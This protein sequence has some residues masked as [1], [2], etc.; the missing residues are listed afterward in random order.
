M[1]NEEHHVSSIISC[2]VLVPDVDVPNLFSLDYM[3]LVCLGVM[4]KLID[5]W[6]SNGSANVRLSSLKIKQ[7]SSSL[8]KLRN[9]ITNDFF[10]IPRSIEEYPRFKATELRQLLLYTGPIALKNVLSTEC[11][12]HFMALNIAM[13]ILLSTD[14]YLYLDY[15]ATLLDYFVK[16]FEQM[17]GS[18]FIS[19]NVHSLLHLV[20]D[21]MKYGSLDN[22]SCFPFENYMKILK[23]MIRKHDNPL[24]QIIKRFDEIYNNDEVKFKIH[25]NIKFT[26]KNPDCFILTYE[27]EVV[28][29]IEI[30][31]DSTTIVGQ[32]Y[33]SKMD[34][35]EK[36][37]RSSKLNIFTVSNLS[38]NTK[39]W[40]VSKI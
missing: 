1:N 35:F 7:L 38:E 22:C 37:I 25:H 36:P 30:S 9:S 12:Q 3:H 13:S 23:K 26:A 21:N 39:Q 11:Y 24:Q 28:Q 10:R 20:D 18:H 32:S 34:L 5:L 4:K 6:M 29:I 31:S 27:D 14:H 2:I 33:N 8:N 17:Y 16:T 19:H 15:A 40:S